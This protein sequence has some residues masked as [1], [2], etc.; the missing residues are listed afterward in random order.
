MNSLVGGCMHVNMSGWCQRQK[1]SRLMIIIQQVLY[2]NLNSTLYL[3]SLVLGSLVS[4][5][6]H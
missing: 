3:L 2:Y 6:T 1:K 4:F 5:E